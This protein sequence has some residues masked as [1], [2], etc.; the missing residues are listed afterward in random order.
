MSRARDMANLGSQAGSGLDASD[1]TGGVLPIGVAMEGWLVDY[2]VIAGGGAGGHA[3][4][5]AGGYRL[6]S[7]TL[8]GE[9]SGGDISPETPLTVF[10]GQLYEVQ[11]GYGSPSWGATITHSGGG[12][13]RGSDS[14]A[15]F[16]GTFSYYNNNSRFASIISIGGG[17]GSTEDGGHQ[18]ASGGSGG[19]GGQTSAKGYALLPTQGFDGI[20]ASANSGGT[21]GAGGGAGG[22]G[23]ST[24]I[25]GIGLE[26]SIT[27]TAV[28]RAGGGGGG[29][30]SGYG[31]GHGGNGD[32]GGARSDSAH[33]SGG[34]GPAANKG[35]GGGGGYLSNGTA[36]GDGIVILSYPNTYPDL[37][38]M[39]SSHVCNGQATGSTTPPSPSTTRSGYKCYE[40]TAGSGGISW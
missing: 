30:A 26:S 6:G 23:T 7:T 27:G 11:V 1:I 28:K 38:K 12:T 4:G 18:G 24:N 5:G 37:Q 16:A 33:G 17:S 35:G 15:P 20:N 9:K 3:G 8:T 22:V 13:W 19:G 21:K 29:V 32:W 39:H 34:Y 10:R 31:H 14:Q 2:L 36:G 40:F 25:G